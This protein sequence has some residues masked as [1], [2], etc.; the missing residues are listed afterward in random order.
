MNSL[1]MIKD[2]VPQPH[3]AMPNKITAEGLL[4]TAP[5]ERVFL[6]ANVL[7]LGVVGALVATGGTGKG[8]AVS[9]IAL[10][11][12]S[13][14]DVFNGTYEVEEPGEVLIV[15]GEED[16]DEQHRRLHAVSEKKFQSEQLSMEEIMQI[17]W[18]IHLMP[19]MGQECLL[20]DDGIE[21]LFLDHLLEEAKSIPNLKL[22]VLDP[23]RR[24]YNGEENSSQATTVIVQ[25]ME[26]L[27]TE[28]GATVLGVHHTS[29]PSNKGASLDAHAA[30]G[31]SALTDG[32]R[33]QMNM[34]R[35][36]QKTAERYGIPEDQRG[37]YVE[38]EVSKNNYAPPQAKRII[39]KR[40]GKGVLSYVDLEA[41]GAA[42]ILSKAEEIAKYIEDMV[43]PD[44]GVLKAKF[45]VDNAWKNG[46]FGLSKTALRQHLNMAIDKGLIC[47]K[48]ASVQGKGK[49]PQVIFPKGNGAD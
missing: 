2:A 47:M 17:E 49:P 12:A 19:S 38:M 29:K 14:R 45:I 27:A 41:Q 25:A 24:F 15:S 1:H 43:A 6:L 18:R 4:S 33:F 37:F 36:G 42:V 44:E 21:T 22:I 28:T 20:V 26:L 35:I 34:A 39:L 30:R 8:Y 48:S 7:P 40:N 32:F 10:S 23:L 13:G 46:L 5:P 9:D 16:K 3:I 11:V 31:S